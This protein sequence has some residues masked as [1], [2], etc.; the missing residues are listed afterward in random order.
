MRISPRIK[1]ILR[2]LK[3][4]LWEPILVPLIIIVTLPLTVPLLLLGRLFLWLHSEWEK[5]A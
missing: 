4:M 2:F 3:A 1:H 5:T